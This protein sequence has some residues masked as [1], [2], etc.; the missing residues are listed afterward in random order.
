MATEFPI[1]SALLHDLAEKLKI[2]GRIRKVAIEV[3]GDDAAVLK[4]EYAMTAAEA[5]MLV[6]HPVAKVLAFTADETQE[7]I[8]RRTRNQIA[9]KSVVNVSL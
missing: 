7:D 4:V 1:P 2:E 9:S 8:A 5:E 6:G 3:G